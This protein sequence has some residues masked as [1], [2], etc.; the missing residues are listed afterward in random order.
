M[1]RQELL[2]SLGLDVS[3]VKQGDLGVGSPIDGREIAKV[4]TD[5]QERVRAKIDTA[6]TAFLQW[7][8]VPPPRRGELIRLF[9]EELGVVV[10]MPMLTWPTGQ[11]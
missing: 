9:G 1:D 6:R 7:R 4:H 11:R 2:Q 8:R 3:A 10:N 5:T